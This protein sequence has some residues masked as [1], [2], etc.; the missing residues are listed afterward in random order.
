[1]PPM[2]KK[3]Y[4]L[5][6]ILLTLMIVSSLSLVCLSIYKAPDVDYLLFMNDY[7]NLQ[8]DSLINHIRNDMDNVYTSEHI[9][10]N[11][12]GRVNNANTINISNHDIVIHLGSGYLTYE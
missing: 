5:L 6:E 12:N 8:C 1:M 7:L 4:S 11:E 9:S 10:F 3:G 2:I